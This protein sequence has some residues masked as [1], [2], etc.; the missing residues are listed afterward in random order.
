MCTPRRARLLQHDEDLR[1]IAG[2]ELC[3]V[4]TNLRPDRLR[5]TD[6]REQRQHKQSGYG[7]TH[8]QDAI[9]G[10]R[11]GRVKQYR[12]DCI[13]FVA[14][15]TL[16]AA[17]MPDRVTSVRGANGARAEAAR[18]QQVAWVLLPAA[19]FEPRALLKHLKEFGVTCES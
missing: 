18:Q 14:A 3:D 2:A 5:A 19:A 12:C 10:R 11:E 1:G 4:E 15:L 13:D 6:R 9:R 8:V 17:E 7:R 16:C